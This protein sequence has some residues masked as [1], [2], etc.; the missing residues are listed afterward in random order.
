MIYFKDEMAYINSSNFTLGEFIYMGIGDFEGR[1]VCISVGYK[2]DYCFKKA[3]QFEKLENNKL[4]FYKINKVK[5]GQLI[6]C[7][8]FNITKQMKKEYEERVQ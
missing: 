8:K 3:V 4:N 7:K 1:D 2:I 6:K 5:I